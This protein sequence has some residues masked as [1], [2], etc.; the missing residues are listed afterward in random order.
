MHSLSRAPALFPYLRS[1]HE[2]RG[3]QLL[4]A[5]GPRVELYAW[6]AGSLSKRAFY[7][8]P[9]MAASVAVVKDYVVAADVRES[10]YFLRH[11]SPGCAPCM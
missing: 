5:A 6:T 3:H 4:L 7:D 1:V 9:Y 11:V 10:L 2:F 8:L